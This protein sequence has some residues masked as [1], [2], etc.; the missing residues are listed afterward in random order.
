[1]S[2]F[3]VSVPKAPEMYQWF[4]NQELSEAVSSVNVD[5]VDPPSASIHEILEAS[6]LSKNKDLLQLLGEKSLLDSGLRKFKYMAYVVCDCCLL[7]L[8]VSA[9]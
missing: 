6:R 1:M 7:N 4:E 5:Q 8:F 3:S 2:I 9:N